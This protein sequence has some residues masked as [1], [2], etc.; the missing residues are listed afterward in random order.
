MSFGLH[1]KIGFASLNSVYQG[2]QNFI[3]LCD[4]IS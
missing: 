1:S 2:K 3:L 4:F